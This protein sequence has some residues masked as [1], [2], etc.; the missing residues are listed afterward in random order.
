[1]VWEKTARLVHPVWPPEVLNSV[2]AYVKDHSCFYLEEL[3][4]FIQ[5][6][7]PSV[8]NTSIPTICRALR[9]VLKLSRKKIEKRAREALL[10]ELEDYNFSLRPFYNFP[11][12]LVFVDETSKD[13]RDALRKYA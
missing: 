8:A 5:E 12:Q 13:S 10:A 3:Q 9:H 1:Q 7:H 6:T 11:E 4:S 2:K